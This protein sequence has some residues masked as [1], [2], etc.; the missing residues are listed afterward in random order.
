ML[1]PATARGDDDEEPGIATT[2]SS[3]FLSDDHDS[4]LRALTREITTIAG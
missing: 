3:Y 4:Y 1:R 2:D